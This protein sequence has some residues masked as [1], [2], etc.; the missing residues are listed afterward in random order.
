MCYIANLGDCR[1][2]MSCNGGRTIYAL[3]KDHKPSDEI[4]NR[5][6]LDAGGKIY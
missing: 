1:A 5:R 2:I 6:V 3:S 4:E